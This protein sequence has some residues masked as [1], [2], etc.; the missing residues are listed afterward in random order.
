MI[1]SWQESVD[2]PRLCVEKQRH[3]SADKGQYSQGYG[4]PSGHI[5]L[6]ELDHKEGTA[7]KNWCLQTMILEEPPEGHLDSNEFKPINLKGDQPWIFTGRPDT[8]ASASASVLPMRIQ[9]FPL[10]LTGSISLP[11]KGLS[12]VFSSTTV[13]RHQFFVTLPSLQPSSHNRSC[14]LGRS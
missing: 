11:S 2:K 1:A 13:Q 14:P 7:P 10:R 9:W 3:Y 5:W 8:E 4:L 6:W 12:G